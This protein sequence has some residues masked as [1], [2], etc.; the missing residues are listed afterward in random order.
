MEVENIK[1][2]LSTTIQISQLTGRW[3]DRVY[4]EVKAEDFSHFGR[5][6][7]GGGGVGGRER[8]WTLLEGLTLTV[9]QNQNSWKQQAGREKGCQ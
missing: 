7:P 9:E 4:P 8:E 5:E 1:N 2:C 6:V 3:T